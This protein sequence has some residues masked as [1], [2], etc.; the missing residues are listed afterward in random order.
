MIGK[1][2]LV[3][4]KN[5]RDKEKLKFLANIKDKNSIEQEFSVQLLGVGFSVGK[6]SYIFIDINRITSFFTLCG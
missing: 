2:L 3:N 5:I 4:I 1:H 6:D